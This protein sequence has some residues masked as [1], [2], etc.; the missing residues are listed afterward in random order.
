MSQLKEQ[1]E[2]ETG[3]CWQGYVNWLEALVEKFNCS[4]QS[5]PT[6]NGSTSP[7]EIASHLMCSSRDSGSGE[8]IINSGEF[9]ES[10]RQLRACR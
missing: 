3:E 9:Y 2:H 1:Y 10:I 7:A 8:V 6:N 4:A 5:G